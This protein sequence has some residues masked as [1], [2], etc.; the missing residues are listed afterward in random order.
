[1]FFS[2]LASAGR[3]GRTS[4]TAGLLRQSRL[5][6]FRAF[7][8]ACVCF[9]AVIQT[10]NSQAS[11]A[12]QI[13][14]ATRDRLL[15]FTAD[16]MPSQATAQGKPVFYADNLW[17]YIDGAADPFLL[18]GLK[19]MLHQEYKAG[20][21]GVT[22]DIYFMGNLEN[23]FGIY[24]TERSAKSKFLDIG[25]EGY[26]GR[27]DD[28]TST[29]LNF[30]LDSYYI[31]LMGFGAGSD[32]ALDAF[33]RAIATRIGAAPGWPVMLARL[34]VEGRLPHT[35]LYVLQNPLGHDYLSPAFS[36]QYQGEKDSSMLVVSVAADQAEAQSRLDLLDKHLR[37]DGKS[38]SA[39]DLGKNVI[40][41]STSYEGEIAAAVSGRYL[42]L[43]VNPSGSAKEAFRKALA[44]LQ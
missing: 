42:V 16:P 25:T 8:A 13:D 29:S 43:M 3:A 36:V 44:Q 40:L 35:E 23:A 22:V 4:Q 2:S 10:G 6:A 30:F 1:V 27:S 31:K 14:Q 41:G 24:A 32:S 17:E 37:K 38:A 20:A 11:A 19:A 12:A 34:P 28:G 26:S 9:A 33:G 7:L 39:P 5:P 18:Y 21:V 15:K